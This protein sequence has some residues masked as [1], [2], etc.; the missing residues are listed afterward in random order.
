VHPCPNHTQ[1]PWARWDAYIYSRDPELLFEEFKQRGASFVKELCY[2]DDGLWGFEVTDADGYVLAFFHLRRA[3]YRSFVV[4]FGF[5]LPF[6]GPGLLGEA[7]ELATLG[8][9]EEA[10]AR[11]RDFLALYADSDPRFEP[12]LRRARQALAPAAGG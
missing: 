10:R 11:Y 1:H 7:E 8:R 4:L 2:I 9:R 12:L 3:H 5:D 6:R